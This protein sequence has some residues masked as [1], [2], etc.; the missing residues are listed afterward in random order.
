MVFTRGTVCT[1]GRLDLCK[2]VIGPCGI[3][4]LLKSLEIDS[5][6]SKPKV[7]HLLL[8]NNLCGN[9]LGEAVGKF[10]K[11]GKSSLTSWYIA[12]N[13]LDENG[14]KPV[15]EALENDTLV[16]QLWLKRNPIKLGGIAHIVNM[17]KTN[18]YLQVL[19][20]TNTGIM[21][22][23]AILLLNN[24]SKSLKYLYLS[25]NGLTDKTCKFIAENIANIKL[26]QISLGCNRLTDSG[27]K[28]LGQV[29]ANPDCTIASLEIASCAIGQNGIEYIADA[30]KVN[31]SLLK[32]NLGFLK[33]TNDI[34][35]IPNIIGSHGAIH[36]ANM[37]STNTTLR[38]I[39][40]SHTGI[41]KAG[42]IA[43][44][45]AMSLNNTVIA[46]NIIQREVPQKTLSIEI[47]K[48]SVEKNRKLIPDD[49][50]KE[51]YDIIEPPHLQEIKSV[52]RI[53]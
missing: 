8:G 4:D 31:T 46:L 15:C 10:I 42:L 47:I 29:L 33:S 41:L 25:S 24:L 2:Q 7:K 21:D 19:D 26:T 6:K 32:L 16:R 45:D 13:D 12:G 9:E 23:G 27:A 22:E 17:L 1:D 53:K 49:K 35:E 40:L 5:S 44:S 39:D 37:L 18:S 52:Y 14:I 30:L 50:F 51:I 28:Y 34:D 43:I 11:S 36:F 3:K 38:S 20:L 48:K